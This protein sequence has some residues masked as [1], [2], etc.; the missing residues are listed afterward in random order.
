MCRYKIENR[1][2]QKNAKLKH[3]E[4]NKRWNI[5]IKLESC[6]S[7]LLIIDSI[8]W[9]VIIAL[10]KHEFLILSVKKMAGQFWTEEYSSIYL[11]NQI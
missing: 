8:A 3:L 9:L 10:D 11:E 2:I 5:E 7:L 4:F 1:R 6:T